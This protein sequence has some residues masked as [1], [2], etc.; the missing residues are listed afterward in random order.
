MNRAPLVMY[1]VA[2]VAGAG[3]VFVLTRRATSEGATYAQRIGAT[4]LLALA[5]ILTVF[6]SAMASW[7]PGA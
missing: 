1:A 3:G 5:V 4:M 6:A 2:G 7:G